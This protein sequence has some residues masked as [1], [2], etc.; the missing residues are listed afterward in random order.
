[1]Q[2][3]TKH[4]PVK[5]AF[6]MLVAFL[7]FFLRP[8]APFSCSSFLSG[9]KVVVGGDNILGKNKSF[10]SDPEIYVKIWSSRSSIVMGLKHKNKFFLFL[11]LSFTLL[12]LLSIF[13][14]FLFSVLMESMEACLQENWGVRDLEENKGKNNVE[15]LKKPRER[16]T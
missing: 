11:V 8:C 15:I 16:I 3:R 5:S 1:M 7:S 6:K 9:A 12:F 10:F 13:F 4:V 2:V 14:S